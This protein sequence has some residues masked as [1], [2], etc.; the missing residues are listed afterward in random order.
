MT[1]KVSR[2]KITERNQITPDLQGPALGIE[3]SHPVKG[4]ADGCKNTDSHP[5]KHF[6]RN[7]GNPRQQQQRVEYRR[8]ERGQAESKEG[9]K[10][11]R[12]QQQPQQCG[13]TF[14]AP[15]E[16]GKTCQPML[17]VILHESSPKSFA[18]RLSVLAS[19]QFIRL[20]HPAASHGLVNVDQRYKE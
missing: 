7:S 12:Q 10:H 17:Q 8:D 2:D 3:L 4:D 5:V 15:P 16:T 14:F 19:G 18:A 20:V 1:T 6:A 11:E 9:S 13:Q